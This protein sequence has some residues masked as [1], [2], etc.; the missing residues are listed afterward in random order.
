MTLCSNRVPIPGSPSTCTLDTAIVPVPSFCLAA[1]FLLLLFHIKKKPS[2]YAIRLPYPGWLHN[3]Y[4]VLVLA[5]FAMTI[6]E[7]ARLIAQD[8]G[9]GLLPMNTI[10]LFAVM[11][12]IWTERRGRTRTIVSTLCAYW[13]LLASVETVK[14]VR[15][16]VLEQTIPNK[17]SSPLYPASDQLLDNVV[18]MVLYWLFF[19]FELYTSIKMPKFENK[20]KTFALQEF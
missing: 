3:V 7:I 8:L 2:E 12:V 1:V 18:M 10:A 13:L 4:A 15:L 14:V 9:V 5:A 20:T 11:I 16:N 19:I 17:L 6:L